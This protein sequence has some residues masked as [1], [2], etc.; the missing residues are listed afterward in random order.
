MKVPFAENAVVDLRKLSDYLLDSDHIEGRHKAILWRA[1]LE[2]SAE[3][4][5]E[6]STFLLE[7]VRSNDARVGKLDDYG[8]RYTVDFVLEW[9]GKSAIIRSGWIIC[10]GSNVPRLT[11]AY[12]R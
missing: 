3:N 8:Q 2:I 12:P 4:A 9:R 11:T 6:V 10:H 7:A 5:Q 1:A